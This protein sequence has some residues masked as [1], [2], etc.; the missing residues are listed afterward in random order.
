MS[1]TR[2]WWVVAAI[3]GGLAVKTARLQ[4]QSGIN[5]DLIDEVVLLRHWVPANYP[6]DALR[7]KVSGDV[8]VRFVSDETGKV[9]SARAFEATDDRLAA[10]AVA[11]V[12]QW[13]VEPKQVDGRY[14]ATGLDAFFEFDPNSRRKF[15]A[16][17]TPP[18]SALPRPSPT[19]PAEV[20]E[21]PEGEYPTSLAKLRL[22]GRVGFRA[23]VTE[24]GKV[25]PTQILEATHVDFVLPAIESLRTWTFKPAMQGDLAVASE[26][27]GA[28]TFTALETKAAEVLELC[29]ITRPDGTAPECAPAI[30]EACDAVWPWERLLAG[31]GGRVLVEFD[32]WETG[33]VKN[34]VVIDASAREF[35]APAI[36]AMERWIFGPAMED[37]GLFGFGAAP[38]K[39]ER[40]RLRRTLDFVVPRRGADSSDPNG[41]LIDGWQAGEIGGAKG[42][43]EK[44]TPIYRVAPRYPQELRVTGGPAGRAEVEFVIDREGRARLPRVVS[45][46]HEAFGW[47]AATA[48]SQWVFRS[49]R[50][51]GAA[52]DVKV[53]IPFDFPAPKA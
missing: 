17:D 19:Q 34:V 8:L 39:L 42:L 20:G 27:N 6:A 47:A 36:A 53:R 50:R 30:V 25:K 37:A 2:S 7:E 29:K 48:V 16:G 51:G 41:R 40:Q 12:M 35:G 4:A 32:V 21:T 33:Q 43:D 13:E 44:L 5:P 26:S 14:V 15:K 28:V 31:E 1:S 3:M 24:A 9:R 11:A 23:V 52:V 46:T 10:A 45:A 38:Q 49:P 22:N 18:I